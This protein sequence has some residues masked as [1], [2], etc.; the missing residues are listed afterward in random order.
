MSRLEIAA[1]VNPHSP[2]Q[3]WVAIR[4]PISEQL[5]RLLLTNIPELAWPRESTGDTLI[6]CKPVIDGQRHD[7]GNEAVLE[8]ANKAKDV[9][10]QAIG[11]EATV[12]ERVVRHENPMDGIMFM[13]PAV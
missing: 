10:T 5:T 3:A 6:Q 9:L 4:P 2:N 7:Y 8:I 11:H 12:R 13:G 1:A